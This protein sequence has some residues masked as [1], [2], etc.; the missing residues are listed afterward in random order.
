MRNHVFLM[1]LCL[2]SS[3]SFG[4]YNFIGFK[5]SQ[6]GIIPDLPY[7]VTYYS[8]GSHVNCYSL[9]FNSI[10]IHSECAA[11]MGITVK[12]IVFINDSTFYLIEQVGGG[13]FTVYKTE[14]SG[15][16]W[17][18]MGYSIGFKRIFSN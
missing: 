2:Y 9:Y 18:Q 14:N 10:C 3:L 4:Q 17:V 11:F 7:S 15:H 8:G 5:E 6:C 16:N 12:D 13:Y 1:L